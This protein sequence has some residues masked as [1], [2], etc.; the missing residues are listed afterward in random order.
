MLLMAATNSCADRLA[1]RFSFD[2]N[3][4][5]NNRVAQRVGTRS[6]EAAAA[7]RF[8]ALLEFKFEPQH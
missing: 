4:A 7:K 1:L 5:D 2:L 8:S 6:K 3:W